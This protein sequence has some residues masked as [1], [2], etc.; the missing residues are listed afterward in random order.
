MDDYAKQWLKVR[1]PIIFLPFGVMEVKLFFN[2]NIEK[3]GLEYG[4]RPIEIVRKNCKI[5]CLMD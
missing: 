1:P 2:E 3:K 5:H 4:L